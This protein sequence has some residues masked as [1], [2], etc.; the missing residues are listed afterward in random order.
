ML[1]VVQYLT[2]T[3]QSSLRFLFHGPFLL[4]SF[5]RQSASWESFPNQRPFS[6]SAEWWGR[7]FLQVHECNTGLQNSSA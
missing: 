4:F 1:I 7:W 6:T 2:A 3:Q 5:L